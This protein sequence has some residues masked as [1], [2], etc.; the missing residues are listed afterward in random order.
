MKSQKHEVHVVV[1]MYITIPEPAPMTAAKTA[2][3]LVQEAFKDGGL[4]TD[5]CKI[6]TSVTETVDLPD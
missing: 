3:R 5:N 4:L 6:T 1:D 2:Y